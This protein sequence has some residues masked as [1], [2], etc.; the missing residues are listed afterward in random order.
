[1]TLS[2]PAGSGKTRLATEAARR[3]AAA[4]NNATWFVPLAEVR[5]PEGLAAAIAAAMGI[6]R[7]TQV[8]P[9]EQVIA[10]LQDAASRV[11]LVL[12]N[13]EQLL[14]Q[15]A[16][17]SLAC[18]AALLERIPG[19]FFLVTSRQRLNHAGERELPILPLPVPEAGTAMEALTANPSVQLFV[20]RAQ[21][22]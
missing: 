9:L 18:L 15:G 2:G 12:D 17:V 21:A 8:D 7:A 1:V 10:A 22:G 13:F 16:A 20:D 14:G 5:E 3:L 11:L 4:M 6:P 19:L